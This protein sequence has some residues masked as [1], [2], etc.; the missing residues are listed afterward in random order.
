MLADFLR[1][2]AADTCNPFASNQRR[3]N[4]IVMALTA[5][6]LI[7]K[8]YVMPV[9]GSLPRARAFMPLL[10]FHS[11]RFVGLALLDPR[12]HI[13]ATGCQRQRGWGGDPTRASPEACGITIGLAEQSSAR[14]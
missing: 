9:L 1:L 10:L 14:S 11:F 2:R 4:G 7:A 6:G 12:G 8:W 5:Y 3:T 13:A